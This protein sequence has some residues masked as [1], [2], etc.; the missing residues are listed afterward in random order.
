MKGE[1]VTTATFAKAVGI[2]L[3]AGTVGGASTH[4]G[5]NLSKGVASEVGKAATR[6]SVQA[7]SAAATDASL[8]YYDKGEIDPRQLM[9]TTAGQITVA[10]TA[11]IS[12]NVSK[13]TD[14]YNKKINSELIIENAGKDSD[15]ITPEKN[16]EARE[17]INSLPPEERKANLD[18]AYRHTEA[19][20]KTQKLEMHRENLAKINNDAS[21]STQQKLETKQVYC[22]ENNLPNSKTS[23]YLSR[24]IEK[25]SRVAAQSKPGYIGDSKIHALTGD[26]VGQIAVDLELPN[27]ETGKRSSERAIF[28]I[29]GEKAV[30]VDH[31]ASH[32]YKGCRNSSNVISDPFDVLRPEQINRD[33]IDEEDNKY[34]EKTE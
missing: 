12:Q 1:E 29:H 14:L 17:K 8:Q 3:V 7:A 23:R 10:T 31:T 4:L 21:L 18:K 34:K 32:D 22:K 9:L 5:S 15:K 13:R 2:G 30:Y 26:R 24:G 27:Q 19:T 28:K 25:S 33:W 6:V 16:Q 20:Q 11:E